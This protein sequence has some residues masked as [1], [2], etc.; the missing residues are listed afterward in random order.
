MIQLVPAVRIVTTRMAFV[1]YLLC[2]CDKEAWSFNPFF[3]DNCWPTLY[4]S[5]R[6]SY[7]YRVSLKKKTR[8]CPNAESVQ[9][10][11]NSWR[12]YALSLRGHPVYI[13]TQI[14]ERHTSCSAYD[15]YIWG[16]NFRR[17]TRCKNRRYHSS[18]HG[19]T[20]FLLDSP[21]GTPEISRRSPFHLLRPFSLSLS[22]FLPLITSTLN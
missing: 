3:C 17:I 4:G 14:R 5:S 22:L 21:E 10:G 1:I 19:K 11:T 18:R 15:H 2:F 20:K 9:S 6:S 8:G 13:V 12:C 7:L 16:Y